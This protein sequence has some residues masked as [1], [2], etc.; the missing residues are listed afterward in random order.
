MTLLI[1]SAITRALGP[2][3]AIVQLWSDSIRSNTNDAVQTVSFLLQWVFS[4]F[5]TVFR[6][7]TI[8]QRH[9]LLLHRRFFLTIPHTH[10]CA[11]IFHYR[12]TYHAY[13][14]RLYYTI[15]ENFLFRIFFYL[16]NT[17]YIFVDAIFAKKN[18]IFICAFVCISVMAYMEMFGNCSHSNENDFISGL[19]TRHSMAAYNSMQTEWQQH[20]MSLTTTQSCSF[21]THTVTALHD[22]SKYISVEILSLVIFFFFFNRTH[23]A[24]TML[25]KEFNLLDKWFL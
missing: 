7:I 12:S 23:L 1:K 17:F 22:S 19:G 10:Y 14:H 18:S 20:E 15:I 2:I 21:M 24:N 9:I 13:V 6:K 25:L 4:C 5:Y 16:N 3:V 11:L 8:T